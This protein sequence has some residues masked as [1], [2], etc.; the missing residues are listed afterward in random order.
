MEGS[1]ISKNMA[2]TKTKKTETKADGFAVI[3]TGGKQYVVRVGDNLKIEKFAEE[4]KVGDKVVFDKVLLTES[5]SDT[6]IGTPHISGVKVTA[7]VVEVGALPKVM[8]IHYKQKSKYFKKYGHKQPFV[9]VAI[10]S[11]K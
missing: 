2:T 10:E 6:N 7:S 1:Y 9:K 5:G 8:V 3:F 11:I 4:S